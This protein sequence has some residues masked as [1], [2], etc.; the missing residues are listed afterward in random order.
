[1]KRT[2]LPLFL[3]LA[4]TAC[5]ERNKLSLPAAAAVAAEEEAPAAVEVSAPEKT[6]L[7]PPVV[8]KKE[9]PQ[10]ASIKKPAPSVAKT[11]K[12]NTKQEIFSGGMMTDGLDIGTVRLGREGTTTRLV[13][14]SYKWNM[15]AKTPSVRSYES[16]YYTVTYDPQ[17]RRITAVVNGYRGF[18]ALHGAKERSF[19][20]NSMVKKLYL[21]KY[22][23]DSGYKFSIELKHNAKVN[24]F[25]LK[26]PAR[27]V[28]DISPI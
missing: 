7:T 20:T 12:S 11:A 5:Q 22:L 19:G 23:D 26:G 1:M 18:S 17:A 8:K 24:V 6:T 3:L 9:K 13:F 25:D 16:G 21:E 4:L 10:D 15:D 28:I 27:I 2:L 14:D